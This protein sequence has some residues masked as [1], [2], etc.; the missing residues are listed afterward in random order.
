MKKLTKYYYGNL[1]TPETNALLAIMLPILTP[2]MPHFV[3]TFYS[4]LMD[5]ESTARF[6]SNELVEHRLTTELAKWLAQTFAPKTA[7]EMVESLRFQQRIGE[8]HAR[9]EIPMSLVN[10]AMTIIKEEMFKTMVSSDLTDRE[11][12][13]SVVLINRI[14]DG[15][16][17]LIND[18]YLRGKVQNERSTLEYRSASSAHELALEIER[19][20]TSLYNW[21]TRKM[22]CYFSGEEIFTT[23]VYANDFGLWIKH[24]FPLICSKP[25]RYEKVI[26][27]LDRADAL[28]EQLN[29]RKNGEE[30]RKEMSDF[31]ETLN[32]VIWLLT[33]EADSS[34]AKESKQD[35]LTHLLERR[36]LNPI[37]QQETKLA[38][39]NGSS[40]AIIMADIDNFKQVNDQY[41]HQVGDQVLRSVSKT[42]KERIRLTDYAFR[43][44]GEEVLILTPELDLQGATDMAER[45]RSA[46]EQQRI[47]LGNEQGINITV[48][49]GIAVF[50]GHPDFLHLIN[51]ADEKLYEAK[52]A[53]RN[54]I[55]Y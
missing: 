12:V 35:A 47:Q 28:R 46:V 34:L 40:Y 52:S 18:S 26:E 43:Y 38:I 21:M 45:I 50:Q 37:L 36:F 16:V 30:G 44:G 1:F 33:D 4:E 17:S 42:I 11:K 5:D 15:A 19:V 32:E 53:G 24:K 20:K 13:R 41:G 51:A 22:V 29:D 23:S 3:H 49:F 6:L 9:V 27:C 39:Q 25:E 8:V 31:T 10:S 55:R 2:A 54:C 48:S 7:E 14:L